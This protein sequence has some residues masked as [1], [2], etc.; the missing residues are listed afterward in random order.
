MTNM[1]SNPIHIAVVNSNPIIQNYLR[2]LINAEPDLTCENMYANAED[3]IT[4][5]PYHREVQIVITD[6]SLPMI[7]GIELIRKLKPGLDKQ[8]KNG[9]AQPAKFLVYTALERPEFVEKAMQAGAGGYI[10]QSDDPSTTVVAAIREMLSGGYPLSL[11]IARAALDFFSKATGL[12]TQEIESQPLSEAEKKVLNLLK[13]GKSNNS[14]A[15][16]LA[17][18]EPAVQLHLHKIFQKIHRENPFKVTKVVIVEDK[19]IEREYYVSLINAEPDFEC[20]NAYSNEEEARVFLRNSTD[21]DIVIV[22]I[23]LGMGAEGIDLVREMK[24]F[25]DKKILVNPQSARVQ[26]L[27][28]TG[29]ERPE[30]IFRAIKSGASGY[31]LKSDSGEEVIAALRDLRQGGAPMSPTVARQALE[32]ISNGKDENPESTTT[33]N[34]QEWAKLSAK[35]VQIL[36][37]IAKGKSNHDIGVALGIKEN[38]VKFRCHRIFQKIHVQNRL[39]AA[40]V[41]LEWMKEKDKD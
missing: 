1:K 27:I 38:N 6:I 11:N 16:E 4:L 28:Y 15:K 17:I 26:F 31:I 22:D 37:L 20:E 25:F 18:S 14:I 9:N 41:W 2:D 40:I 24:E 7:T 32:F 39:E 3:A 34:T 5:L 19:K 36:E 23:H 35:E 33:T 12:N 21:V 8:V 29:L 30:L 10:L 13:I